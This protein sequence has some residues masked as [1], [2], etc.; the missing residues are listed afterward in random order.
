MPCAAIS[1]GS[2]HETINRWFVLIV[3]R[4]NASCPPSTTIF[5][6]SISSLPL[7]P[8]LRASSTLV[9]AHCEPDYGA[10]RSLPLSATVKP[11][12]LSCAHLAL[13]PSGPSRS[14]QNFGGD[15][16]APC[17][18]WSVTSCPRFPS[19]NPSKHQEQYAKVYK[20]NSS[21]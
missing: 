21:S 5:P 1:V 6:P 7:W 9:S 17:G 15:R 10:S 18:T 20:A 4:V 16:M 13:R 14:T 8:L 3:D 11:L 12:E 2:D 19:S